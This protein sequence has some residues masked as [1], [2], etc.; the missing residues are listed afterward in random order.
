LCYKPRRVSLYAP[1]HFFPVSDLYDENEKNVVPNLIYG[2]VILPW[3]D[4][5]TVELLFS[6]QSFSSVRTRVLFQPQDIEVHFS[7]DVRSELAD[8]PLGGGGDF[9]PVGQGL[10]SQFSNEVAE[11]DGPLFFRLF[12]GCA[13][14]FDVN[15]VHFLPSQA[16]QKA[17]VFYRDN[18]GQIFP[19]TGHNRPLLPVSST[20]HEVGECISGFRYAKA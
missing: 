13:G 11:R 15:P 20:V 8:V 3:P 9:D 7:S 5:D 6:L 12:Q 2:A 18:G 10:V 16:L 17:K 14:V 4:T 19:A 1:V